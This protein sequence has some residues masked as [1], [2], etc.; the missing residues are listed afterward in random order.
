MHAA[1][2]S[3]A[4]WSAV[5]P[6]PSAVGALHISRGEDGTY[7]A[8]TAAEGA[9]G[10]ATLGGISGVHNLDARI[11]MTTNAALRGVSIEESYSP[12]RAPVETEAILDDAPSTKFFVGALSVVALL[13]FYRMFER[14]R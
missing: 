11:A 10:A 2:S 3:P 14:Y 5:A 1:P 7:T 9:W 12:A 13:V 6:A 8:A 4:S